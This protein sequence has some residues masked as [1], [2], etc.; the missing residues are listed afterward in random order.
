MKKILIGI[1]LSL[2]LV[3]CGTPQIVYKDRIVK[4]P[5]IIHAPAPDVPHV[6]PLGSL[7]V[8]DLTMESTDPETGRAYVM[9]LE[10]CVNKT[11]QYEEALSVFNKEE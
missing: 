3:G 8:D 2:V 11:E 6:D 5:E 9:S 4:V 10:M 1:L 7:P